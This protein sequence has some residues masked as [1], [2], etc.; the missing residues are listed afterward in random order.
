MHI[1]ILLPTLDEGSLLSQ[2]IEAAFS[3]LTSHHVSVFIIT[4][5]R[6]T[7]PETRA[8][9]KELIISHPGYIESFDQVRP[10]IGCAVREAFNRANGDAVIIMTEWDEIKQ[11]D[12]ARLKR[13]MKQSMIVDTRNVV[14]PEVLKQLGFACDAIG[15]SY[16]CKKPTEYERKFVSMRLRKCIPTKF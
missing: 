7:T 5:A 2:T 16:L 13:V 3:H 14:S 1:N 9:I 8:V 6:F 4:S 15:Q 10:G 12:F 11:I